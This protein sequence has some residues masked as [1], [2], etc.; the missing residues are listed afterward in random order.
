MTVACTAS[1]RAYLPARLHGACMQRVT[2]ML[3]ASRQASPVPS[4]ASSRDDEPRACLSVL[5]YHWPAIA[6]ALIAMRVA[7]PIPLAVKN[8]G[9]GV[10]AAQCPCSCY[11][12]TP[13]ASLE[14]V[15]AATAD[16]R[17]AG[18]CGVAWQRAWRGVAWRGP[19]LPL[20]HTRC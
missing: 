15:Q 6:Q 17:T 16:C 3:K 10:P 7:L 13:P 12:P 8:Y 11:A 9:F 20:V 2:V 4:L 5:A 18:L 14:T 1:R 19:C